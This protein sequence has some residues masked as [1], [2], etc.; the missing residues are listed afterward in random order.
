VWRG[1]N[2]PREA[3]LVALESRQAAVGSAGSPMNETLTATWMEGPNLTQFGS[4]PLPLS[5]HWGVVTDPDGRVFVLSDSFPP[6]DLKLSELTPLGFLSDSQARGRGFTGFFGELSRMYAV[7]MVIPFLLL[8]VYVPVLHVAMQYCR[9]PR[10]GFAHRTVR[11]A[12]I[13]RRA[14]ARI[15]DTL[16]MVLPLAAVGLWWYLAFDLEQF[17]Q[18][19]QANPPQQILTILLAVFGGLT[20]M[21]MLVILFGTLEGVLGWSPGKLLCGLRVV[22][23][24]LQPVGVLRGLIRQFLI[25]IDG[26]FNYLVG[27]AMVAALPKQQRLGDLAADSIVV[28]AAS[29]E[30]L[31]PLPRFG[32]EG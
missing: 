26:Q 14:M 21:L 17:V 1:V 20:Y 18:Q 10:Y 9:N 6:G 15:I 13:G 7:V 16:L 29:L 22:R 11:L 30:P 4:L 19:M 32:G 2:L 23:T 3:V 12:S 24:T 8:A 25:V 31:S 27:A 5:E 28:E